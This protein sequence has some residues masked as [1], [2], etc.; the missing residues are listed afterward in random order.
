M[1]I[2]Y[3]A[4]IAISIGFGFAAIFRYFHRVKAPPNGQANHPS[5]AKSFFD[6]I[7]LLG[8][9]VAN[10]VVGGLLLFGV[11]KFSYGLLGLV[12]AISGLKWSYFDFRDLA[13]Q[14]YDFDAEDVTPWDNWVSIIKFRHYVVCGTMVLVGIILMVFK[15]FE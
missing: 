8:G 14:G 11:L 10:T 1:T 4:T 15:G 9:G 5:A 3:F 7:F 13:L 12:S 6:H 2:L